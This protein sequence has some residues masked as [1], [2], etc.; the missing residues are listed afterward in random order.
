MIQ[1]T[2]EL[3]THGVRAKQ[4]IV[5]IF[6]VKRHLADPMT[7]Y[8]YKFSYSRSCCFLGNKWDALFFEI[9][10]GKWPKS[11]QRSMFHLVFPLAMTIQSTLLRHLYA[12]QIDILEW[13]RPIC[14]QGLRNLPNI[15]QYHLMRRKLLGFGG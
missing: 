3:K 12:F 15:F 9:M 5:R 2:R 8:N 10:Y 11:F 14:V 4:I 1:I 6:K 13:S 7:Y